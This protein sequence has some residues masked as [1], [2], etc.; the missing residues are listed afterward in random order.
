MLFIGMRGGLAKFLRIWMDEIHEKG[1]PSERAGRK[2]M[3]AKAARLCQP[4]RRCFDFA[5]LISERR[6]RKHGKKI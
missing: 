2:T 4:G 1:K 3:G 6:M 5:F